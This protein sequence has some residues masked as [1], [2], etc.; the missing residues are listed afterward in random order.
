MFHLGA[1][2][3][4]RGF[5]LE[6]EKLLFQVMQAYDTRL[7][8]GLPTAKFSPASFGLQ[9][10]SMYELGVIYTKQ[11]WRWKEAEELLAQVANACETQYD[12]RDQP[13]YFSLRAKS[14]FL[15]CSSYLCLGDFYAT[16]LYRW[17]DARRMFT[18]C[19][20]HASQKYRDIMHWRSQSTDNSSFPYGKLKELFEYKFRATTG[21]VYI[22]N[23]QG[24]YEEAEKL[25]N[26][27]KETKDMFDNHI[28]YGDFGPIV[29]SL[30]ILGAD[31]WLSILYELG[32]SYIMQKRWED[33][34]KALIEIKETKITEKAFLSF[35]SIPMHLD[36][37]NAL[38]F[39]Y[40]QQTRWVE[41]EAHLSRSLEI[42]KEELQIPSA[43]NYPF[44]VLD[45]PRYSHDS[46]F[47]A[48]SLLAEAYWGQGKLEKAVEQLSECCQLLEGSSS[49]QHDIK[50]E[51]FKRL[52]EWRVQLNKVPLSRAA[53][54]ESRTMEEA[55][56]G[57]AS[58]IEL[59]V[60]PSV[61]GYQYY[62]PQAEAEMLEAS[63]RDH[64]VI[65][66]DAEYP[67]SPVAA[68][69]DHKVELEILGQPDSVSEADTGASDL[70][71][72][73]EPESN[74]FVSHKDAEKDCMVKKAL[75]ALQDRIGHNRMIPKPL[76]PR[77]VPSWKHSSP[78]QLVP[79]STSYPSP[80][81]ELLLTPF[82]PHTVDP[83]KRPPP[84]PKPPSLQRLKTEP[85]SKPAQK[86]TIQIKANDRIVR[87]KTPQNA[88]PSVT[89][90][91][92]V[93]TQQRGNLNI[94]QPK[95]ES[96]K[97]K[98]K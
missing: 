33:A 32:Y 65:V 36:V 64:R 60:I 54:F 47:R 84:P 48:M 62:E 45:Q 17:E 26:Q 76:R 93:P 92:S 87:T 73:S 72:V 41:A 89:T 82:P 61:S 18:R 94:S 51:R 39:V 29:D 57:M 91:L 59:A 20:D 31:G 4:A 38:G 10:G 3:V 55:A 88:S 19:V 35:P 5:D 42:G 21:L 52:E 22:N 78:L 63:G 44:D 79:T 1:S 6:A 8:R 15:Y 97:P 86:Q 98:G 24:C 69:E 12:R 30:Q 16:Q 27:Y 70:S 49:I 13:G 2:L 14:E 85:P 11:P 53:D 46:V 80:E 37:M 67:G 7:S 90:Q 66:V 77:L 40:L 50:K 74:D 23:I 25:C 58:S 81:P 83:P 56:S 68:N 43:A 96:T 71:V 34:E 9:F 95:K 75:Q 28:I